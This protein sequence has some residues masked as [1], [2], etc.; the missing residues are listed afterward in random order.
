[1]NAI[2]TL[3]SPGSSLAVGSGC[4]GASVAA[5]HSGGNRLGVVGSVVYLWLLS[6]CELPRAS[7]VMRQLPG[8]VPSHE[9][10]LS[11]FLLEDQLSPV[12]Q[13]CELRA[14][15]DVSQLI[16]AQE[17]WIRGD[18]THPEFFRCCVCRVSA[19]LVRE[20]VYGCVYVHLSETGQARV[21]DGVLDRRQLRGSGPRLDW[22][23]FSLVYKELS[24]RGAGPDA[25][26]VREETRAGTEL[27]G[28]RLRSNIYH[29]RN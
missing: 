15:L 25:P 21:V 14:R 20:A 12:S 13:V 3:V 1:M 4:P 27:V 2:L 23:G 10:R 8:Y 19:V 17:R 22:R 7:D 24:R 29:P 16:Y 5:V 11:L 6:Q 28:D 18:S 9:K 26:L